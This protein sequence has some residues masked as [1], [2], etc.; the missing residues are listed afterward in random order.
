[1]HRR[2]ATLI[3]SV[4]LLTSL[5]A[6]G[7]VPP[8]ER[9][10][11]QEAIAAVAQEPGAPTRQL[12][13]QIDDL[14][15][16][17]TVGE[18]RAALVMHNGAIAAERYAPGYDAD[19]RFVSWSMA[20]TITAVMIG[21]LVADGQLRLDDSPPIPEWQRPGDPR[22]EITVR[23][24]LQM[25][26]G[27]RHTEAGDPPY[28]SSEVRMLFLDGRD[29]MAQWAKEQ[30]LEDEPGAK[31]EYSSNTTV[32]LADIAARV[33]AKDSADPDTRRRAVADFLDARLFGPLGMESV[34]AEYDASGTLIGGS[35][36]HANARDWAKFG[37]FLRN[38]GSVDGAQL[39]PSKWVDFMTTSSPRAEFYGAQTW[40]NFGAEAE[41]N[42]LHPI[43]QP[44]G[45]FAAIG[46]MGQYVLVSPGQRL[47]IVRL[48][49]SDTPQR[50]E[51]LAQLRD[52]VELYPVR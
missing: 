18:T 35:L 31:F 21:M 38:R 29:N 33:I 52:V 10:L 25:R 19:T 42:P 14:F 32:I 48:G 13:R 40:L 22:G 47:T 2:Q 17:E 6:C 41:D 43:A 45:V 1:M 51:L 28:D 16:D 44:E 46:H 50:K 36:I 37:E 24:L 9:E 4:T 7:D 30:P 5:V 8:V 34:V 23:Q 39:V 27:L 3:A 15:V 26:S 12:A 49:H 20:K 11:T